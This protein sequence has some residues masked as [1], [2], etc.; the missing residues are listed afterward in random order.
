MS[1]PAESVPLATMVITQGFAIFNSF[2]PDLVEVRRST[3]GDNPEFHNDIRNA[4]TMAGALVIGIG[5]LVSALIRQPYP[6]YVSF[7]VVGGMVLLYEYTYRSKG[8][9]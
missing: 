6:L 7:A 4:E 5:F 2:L 9:S 1:I 3:P 8:V